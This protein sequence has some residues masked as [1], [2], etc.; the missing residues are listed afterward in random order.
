MNIE[1]TLEKISSFGDYISRWIAIPCMGFYTILTFVGVLSRFVFKH[2]IAE[3]IELSRVGFVWSCLMGSAV[4]YKRHKHIEFTAIT[5]RL[6]FR[7]RNVIG[8]I[9][10]TL[11]LVF[12][13]WVLAYSISIT[14]KVW[15]SKLSASGISNGF[16]YLPLPIALVVMLTHNIL[17]IY[18]SIV[19]IVAGER[20]S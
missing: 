14:I 20:V 16:L 7:T 13:I 15:P 8:S 2:P 1:K 17:D 10:S 19:A 12:I 3:A 4:A 9:V 18:K 5:S 11:T 6:P